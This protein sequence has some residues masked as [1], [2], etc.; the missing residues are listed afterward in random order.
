MNDGVSK[1]LNS[2]SRLPPPTLT[3]R[4]ID[5]SRRIDGFYQRNNLKPLRPK[6][7][8][9]F[10]G[11]MYGML[12]QLRSNPDWMGQVANS[13]RE[14]LFPIWYEVRRHN[15][16]DRAPLIKGKFRQFGYLFIEDVFDEINEVYGRFNDL[17]HHGLDPQVFASAELNSFGEVDF[18]KLVD[19]FERVMIQAFTLPLDV[20]N[21]IDRLFSKEPDEYKNPKELEEEIQRINREQSIKE[22]FF[23]K[24]DERWFNWLWENGFLDAIKQKA[25]DPTKYGHRTP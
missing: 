16:N 15:R 12:S 14:L 6:P 17:V 7:S 18:E 5:L 25:K 4:Q 9:I 10:I 3:D 8:E 22:Y 20:F 21:D 11:A 24:T 2:E 1:N 13:L 19:R 23:F